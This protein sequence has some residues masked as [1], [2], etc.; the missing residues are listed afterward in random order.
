MFTYTDSRPNCWCLSMP[1][2]SLVPGKEYKMFAADYSGT[3]HWGKADNSHRP[4][5][6][7]SPVYIVL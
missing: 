1:Y 3:V 5:H 2:K 4:S 6:C 7:S